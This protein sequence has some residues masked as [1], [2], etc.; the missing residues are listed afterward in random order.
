[1]QNTGTR[2]MKCSY[3]PNGSAINSI[4]HSVKSR[5]QDECL[6]AIGAGVW[7]LAWLPPHGRNY[8]WACWCRSGGSVNAYRMEAVR[9]VHCSGGWHLR[10][11]YLPCPNIARNKC[12]QWKVILSARKFA[13]Q[14]SPS[15]VFFC[16][17]IRS[18]CNIILRCSSSRL[19]VVQQ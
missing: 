11:C 5:V 19:S 15:R 8:F 1:M 12:S 2:P 3:R 17:L 4:I 18:N 6:D 16:G 9:K 14:F 10:W 7:N 13:G